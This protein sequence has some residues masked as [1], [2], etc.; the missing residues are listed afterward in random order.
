MTRRA[1]V[2]IV[3]AIT[4]ALAVG[5]CQRITRSVNASV[6]PCFRIL[7]RAHQAVGGQGT[8]VDVARIRG[9]AVTLFRLASQA[10]LGEAGVTTTTGVSPTTAPSTSSTSGAA[11]TRDISAVA[12]KG[13]F[14]PTRIQHLINLRPGGRYAVVI[15]GVRSQK[16]RA[17]LLLDR[18]PAPLHAH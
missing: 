16:V 15:V 9:T 7:P 1:V 11:T 4:L 2:A 8:Y 10:V 18:L 12:Y 6:S 3:A 5:G 17:V 14:D 13:T